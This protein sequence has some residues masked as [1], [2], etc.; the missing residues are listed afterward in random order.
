MRV[1]SSGLKHLLRTVTA[2]RDVVMRA[3][4]GSRR[5]VALTFDDGPNPHNTLPIL[6]LLNAYDAR[7]TFFLIGRKIDDNRSAIVRQ[8]AASGHEIGNHTYSHARTTSTPDRLDEE[9]RATDDAIARSAGVT[10]RVCRPPF[11]NNVRR[12]AA[13][14]RR[15]S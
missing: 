1:S 11:G 2:P 10:V 8:I 7:A 9:L 6:E 13:A 3:D 14:A 15:R 12:F 4:V 5:E